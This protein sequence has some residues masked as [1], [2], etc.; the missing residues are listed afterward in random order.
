MY[1]NGVTG[2][3]E[4]MKALQIQAI[5][6]F[7]YLTLAYFAVRSPENGLALAWSSEIIYWTIQGFL[8]YRVMHSGNW[9]FLKI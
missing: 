9:N 1:C 7:T 4:T 8:S 5:A 2:T 6:C 3:G